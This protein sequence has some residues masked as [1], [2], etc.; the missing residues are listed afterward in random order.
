MYP[1][2]ERYTRFDVLSLQITLVI[3]EITIAPLLYSFMFTVV[4]K[5]G[6]LI[7]SEYDYF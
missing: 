1:I 5:F 7:L 4:R 6:A 2:P 3:N